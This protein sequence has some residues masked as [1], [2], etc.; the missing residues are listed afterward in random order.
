MANVNP[1]TVLIVEGDRD[2][3]SRHHEL[4]Q[5]AGYR[6]LRMAGSAEALASRDEFAVAV[7]DVQLADGDGSLLASE[8]K[9]RQPDCEIILL[10][11][12][13]TLESAVAAMQAGAW[14]YL[15]KPGS[16]DSLLLTVHQALRHVALAE[17]KQQLSRRSVIAEKLAAVGTLAAGLSHEIRN[18]LNAASLQLTL[19]ERRLRRLGSEQAAPLLEP[20][21]LVQQEIRRLNQ[22]VADFMQFARPRDFTPVRVD[23]LAVVDSVLVSLQPQATR[24]ELQVLREIEARPQVEGDASLLQQALLNVAQ[25]AVEATPRGG[26]VRIRLSED[27]GSA[28]LRIEDSGSGIPESIRPRIFEPFFTTKETGSGLG[29]PLVHSIIEQHRGT[30]TIEDSPLGGATLLIR[31]PRPLSPSPH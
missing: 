31:L 30:I 14:D 6:V 26:V 7:I 29:L 8:L 19:L 2:L 28:L 22:I 4:L 12:T 23:L 27:V 15:S 1:K 17:E 20:L 10:S 13:V 25:N 5:S 11:D 21:E 16:A 3:G 18:P 9:R 24:A